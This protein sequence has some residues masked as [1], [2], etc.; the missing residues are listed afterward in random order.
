MVLM[1]NG[2][3]EGGGRRGEGERGKACRGAGLCVSV[4][5]SI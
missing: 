1:G 4:H 5:P 2:G 3:G